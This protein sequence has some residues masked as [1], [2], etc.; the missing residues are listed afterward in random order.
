MTRNG[1][2]AQGTGHRND[3]R[4]VFVASSVPGARCPVP[5]SFLSAAC[6]LLSSALAAHAAEVRV[7]A[8]AAATE[9]TVGQRFAVTVE[10]SGPAGTAWTF[11]AEAGD[12]RVVLRAAT[13]RPPA[14]ASCTY[15][16]AAYAIGEVEVPAIAVKYRLPDGGEGEARS[17]AIPLAIGSLLPKE[18]G[19]RALVD[20]RGPV[21]LPLGPFFWGWLGAAAALVAAVVALA[22]RRRRRPRAT[23]APAAPE[24]PPDVEAI[25]ALDALA[26]SPLLAAADLKPYYVALAEVAKRYLE[27]RLGAPVLEMTSTETVA[28]LR[29]SQAARELT[30]PLRELLLAADQVKFAR[31]HSERVTAERHLAAVR[32]MVALL[33][34]RLRPAETPAP[35]R[36]A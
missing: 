24:L 3:E 35:E 25:A 11:P 8:R 28:L 18:E 32:A 27:R 1:H 29:E 6:V 21:K 13:D 12:D 26:A 34:A 19:E 7:T 17:E 16:A 9:V 22:L 14:A 5:A 20:I 10:A 31:G 2:R 36:G 4:G 23:A 33:E 15:D 30:S